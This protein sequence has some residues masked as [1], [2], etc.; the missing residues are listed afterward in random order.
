MEGRPPTVYG[1]AVVQFYR[2]TNETQYQ[3]SK[4][5]PFSYLSF[6]ISAFRLPHFFHQAEHFLFRRDIYYP[7]TASM[8]A[9]IVTPILCV[10][11]MRLISYKVMFIYAAF[12]VLC[13][14][15]TMTQV[16]HGDQKVEAKKGLEAYENMDD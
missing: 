1:S 10:T 9:Q 5:V 11:L 7:Y 4:S 6:N 2:F 15:A 3:T 16:K 8:S 13:A 12:F 14:F